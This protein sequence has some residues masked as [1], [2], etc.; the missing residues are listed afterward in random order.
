[1]QSLRII[2][3]SYL[4]WLTPGLLSSNLF[5]ITMT[6]NPYVQQICD[7]TGCTRWDVSQQMRNSTPRKREFPLTIHGVTFDT[8]EEYESALHDFLNGN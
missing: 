3:D 1:M 4:A 8:K 6:F 2:Q 5:Q 7:Q